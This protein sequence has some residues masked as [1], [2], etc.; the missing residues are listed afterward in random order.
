[1]KRTFDI[2]VS[3][4]AIVALGIVLLWIAL[5][6]K[7]DSPGPV[8]FRQQRVGQGG[9]LFTILKFRS[10]YWDTD[11]PSN[12]VSPSNDPRITRVGRF[13]RAWYFDELPQLFNVLKGDMSFVGPR[14]ETPEFIALLSPEERRVLSVRPGIAGPSTLAFMDEGERLSAASDPG[15]LYV[16]EILHDRVRL[17]LEYV[18]SASI[19]YDIRLLIRQ[20]LAIVRS[21]S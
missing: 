20:A 12:N 1:M 18:G 8:L 2:V 16:A 14:P 15:S 11:R 19:A 21:R 13:I 9:R 7:I 6:V 10:M 5:A 4:L 3:S 17:D